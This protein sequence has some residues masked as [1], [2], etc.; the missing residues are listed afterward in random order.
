[1]NWFNRLPGFVPS[2]PGIERQVLRR[3]P[4]ALLWGSLVLVLP[5]LLV[6]LAVAEGAIVMDTDIAVIALLIL[7]WTAVPTV[8][9]A[10]FIVMAMKGP[11]YVADPYPLVEYDG[12]SD[13][14]SR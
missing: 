9:L 6:R 13:G 1:M 11:A 14:K 3:V 12:L 7:W 8:A 5:F 2:L 10:A 4:A